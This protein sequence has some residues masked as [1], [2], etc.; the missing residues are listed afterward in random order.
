MGRGR[1]SK[2]PLPPSTPDSL[3]AATDYETPP[4]NVSVP[5]TSDDYLRPRGIM[6]MN[7]FRRGLIAEFMIKGLLRD[8]SGLKL[9][10][11]GSASNEEIDE[12]SKPLGLCTSLL[13]F[14]TLVF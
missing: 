4:H 14:H 11:L 6:G 8:D 13:L 2:L 10:E 1:I 5:K 7:I 9:P 3:A 12:I